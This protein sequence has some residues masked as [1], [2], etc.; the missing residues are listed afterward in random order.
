LNHHTLIRFDLIDDV[1]T[2]IV[3]PAGMYTMRNGCYRTYQ[4]WNG[5]QLYETS[6]EQ[7][8]DGFLV[9]FERLRNAGDMTSP[10]D[11][12]KLINAMFE[13]IISV[14]NITIQEHYK[15]LLAEKL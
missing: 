1:L 4:A 9:M 15:S 8:Q 12:Q 3:L 5:K 6:L 11:K 7:A 2:V 10:I 14:S 13:L